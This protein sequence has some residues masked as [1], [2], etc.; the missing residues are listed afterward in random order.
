MKRKNQAIG[1]KVMIIFRNFTSPTPTDIGRP[2]RY[3]HVHWIVFF[4]TYIAYDDET[5]P[6]AFSVNSHQLWHLNPL[7]DDVENSS[8][9]KIRYHFLLVGNSLYGSKRISFWVNRQSECHIATMK[10]HIDDVLSRGEIVLGAFG[11]G[12]LVMK[13][14]RNHWNIAFNTHCDEQQGLSPNYVVCV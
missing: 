1:A 4:D 8:S 5:H 12:F 9:E 3:S 7:S 10:S 6:K 13:F 2:G 14:I 11:F